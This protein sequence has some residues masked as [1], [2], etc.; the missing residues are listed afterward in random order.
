MWLFRATRVKLGHEDRPNA[1]ISGL[2]RPLQRWNGGRV[3][4]LPWH[5]RAIDRVPR[6]VRRKMLAVSVISLLVMGYIDYATG[7]E[8][9]FSAA[10]LLPVSL[11]AWYLGKREVWLMSV[12]AGFTSWYV[13]NGH[14]YAHSATQFLNSFVCFVIS[15]LCGLLL[16][17][18]RRV[19]VEREK[20]N[21]DLRLSLEEL[22][23]STAEIRKLQDGLQVVCAW[24]KQVKVGDKWMTADEFLT[25]HLH[26]RVSHGISP[27]AEREFNIGPK[28]DA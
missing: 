3:P 17:N 26:I 19:E 27:E 4:G 23:R 11:C 5:M 14:V 6:A 22:A 28:G 1:G 15:I 21:R 24:T 12:A 18:L 25:T 2:S 7:Y 16:L 8:L 9:V 10:Y 13:D 20:T